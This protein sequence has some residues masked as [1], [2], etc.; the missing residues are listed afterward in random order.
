MKKSPFSHFT[1]HLIT[2]IIFILFSACSSGTA[3]IENDE[4][5]STDAGEL[6]DP[7]YSS[8]DSVKID[9]QKIKERGYIT[10]ITGYN[11]TSYFI[12]RGRPMGYEYE[13]LKRLAD[14]LGV[15]LKIK[16][17]KNMD[18]V[19]NMLNRGEGDI[20]AYSL[21]IT[22]ER[23]K[24]VNFTNYNNT[25]RQVL[26]QKKPENWRKMNP[27][28][29]KRQL[30]ENVIELLDKEVY[31]R[32]QSAYFERL[33]NLE[34]EIGGDIDIKIAGGDKSTEELIEKVEEGVI[35][36]TVADENIALIN[37]AYNSD[38]DISVPISF[39]QRIA[40]AVRTNSPN[41]LGAVNNWIDKNRGTTVYNVI[42]NKYFKN[43]RRF[44][45]RAKSKYFSK[46]G[47]YLSPYDS[48]L[49]KY[50]VNI[51]WD[52]KLLA[53]QVYQESKFDPKTESWAGARGL[54]QLMPAT[55][56]QFDVTDPT[57]P[58]QSIKAGTGYIQWIQEK[59]TDIKDPKERQ[60]FVLASY[61]VGLGHVR[62]A[63][64]L[65]KK[66][67]DDP[68]K[69]ADVSEYLLKKSKEEF[70]ND[71]VVKYGYCRGKEPYNYVEEILGRY[72]EYK[73]IFG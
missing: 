34:A 15:E 3:E 61:N 60:K 67:G 39:P 48:L 22:K 52:W 9:L 24:Y 72:E 33:K 20:I 46:K 68:Q 26:V 14:H 59:L 55:A 23:K 36:R 32:K 13:L 47:D 69:W 44:L 7:I 4:K 42:Y 43:Q 1:I 38:I 50:A 64:R 58:G 2:L 29:V 10:A 6:A 66:Y 28:K 19:F 35:P 17:A 56:K 11:N 21:T 71:P 16:L 12:F 18:Q 73:T 54:M 57:V 70:F 63:Q 41:L 65:A 27:S 51:G 49:K 30:V 8:E 5:A 53:S 31:V 40:W 45:K 25:V 37:K 62:D